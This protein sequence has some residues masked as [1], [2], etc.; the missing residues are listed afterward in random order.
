[1]LSE[2]QI[3]S[4]ASRHALMYQVIRLIPLLPGLFFPGLGGGLPKSY[5]SIPVGVHLSVSD[6]IYTNSPF[7]RCTAILSNF[8]IIF[9][10]VKPLYTVSR[11]GIGRQDIRQ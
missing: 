7:V 3:K 4:D 1:M 8:I 11:S 2:N 10:D 9:P 6:R 5:I